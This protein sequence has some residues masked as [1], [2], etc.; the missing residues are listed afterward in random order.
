MNAAPHF[1]LALGR[2]LSSQRLYPPEHPVRSAAIDEAYARLRALA[3]QDQ[4]PTFTFLEHDILY[5]TS[6]MPELS[7][8]SAADRMAVAGIER[9]EVTWPVPRHEFTAFIGHAAS[10]A[11]LPDAAAGDREAE[12][13]ARAALH[14]SIRFGL[15]TVPETKMK[16]AYDEANLRQLQESLSAEIDSMD[17]VLRSAAA[18]EGIQ[19]LE[20]D[21][22]VG[23]LLV[24]VASGGTFLVPLVRLRNADQY[25]VTHSLNVASLSMALCEYVGYSRDQVRAV[26]VSGVLHDIG[27]VRT[28]REVLT[29]SG[30]LTPE[31][32][33]IMNRHPVDGARIIL[34][35]SDPDLDLAAIVAYEHHIRYDGGGYPT[36]SRRRPCHPASDLLHVCD[37]FDALA[38]HRPYRRAWTEARTL[39]MIEEQAG[40]EFAP[41]AATAFL[42]MMRDWQ[43]RFVSRETPEPAG[44]PAA[45]G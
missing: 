21:A 15:A 9:I 30:P 24:A 22:I 35:S 31:E 32:R 16:V 37:V 40:T 6:L 34:E 8:W 4:T 28:P 33:E 36:T 29:K 2:A 5:G 42:A 27:K 41:A 3:E 25:T 23:S 26:G 11:G 19:R 1:L 39:G 43:G 44:D 45:V 18:D 10:A 20:V 14:P 17:Y 38:T 7:R 12:A 13:D